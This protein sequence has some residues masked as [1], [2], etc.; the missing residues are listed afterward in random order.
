LMTT[1]RRDL[2]DGTLA[3]LFA[4]GQIETVVRLILT[5]GDQS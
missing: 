3:D 5:A 2:D 4:R 1:P